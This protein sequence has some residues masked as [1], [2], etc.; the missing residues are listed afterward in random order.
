MKEVYALIIS[1]CCSPV[2]C[3]FSNKKYLIKKKETVLPC[4]HALPD[5]DM[6]ELYGIYNL[7]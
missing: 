3:L 1:P 5:A 4:L 6:S 2:Y 7:M